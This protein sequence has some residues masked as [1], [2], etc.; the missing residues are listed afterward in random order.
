MLH[1]HVSM[2]KKESILNT[3]VKIKACVV[4]D[5][6]SS[7]GVLTPWNRPFSFVGSAIPEAVENAFQVLA[8]DETR[9]QFKPCIWTR[10]ESPK[11]YTKQCWFLG[12]HADV[13]G[14]GDAALGAVTLIWIIGQLQART[15]AKF[16]QEEI[17]KHLR[18]R[19]LEWDVDKNVYL[20]RL[21]QNSMLLSRSSTGHTT[22]SSP[23]WWFLGRTCRKLDMGIRHRNSCIDVEISIHCTVRLSMIQEPGRCRRLRKWHTSAKA[24]R[25]YWQHNEKSLVEE[26]I[27]GTGSYEYTVLRTW[28]TGGLP[29]FE[30]DRSR[31]ALRVHA[32]VH[33]P[34]EISDG[35]RGQFALVLREGLILEDSR[36]APSLMYKQ[37]ES[38]SRA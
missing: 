36:L 10:K 34:R 14:N 16:A 37:R 35:S 28:S 4:W 2:F 27:G 3:K 32:L 6:V 9:A 11:T 13:G 8:L 31:F 5:T 38:I 18:H 20:G 15:R 7:L 19:F 29:Q 21:R 24:D 30:T 22:K 25:V 17:E 12:S 33:N 26:A 1:D 23:L